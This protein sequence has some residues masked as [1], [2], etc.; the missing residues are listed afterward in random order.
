MS[1]VKTDEDIREDVLCQMAWDERLAGEQVGVQVAHG[2]VTLGGVVDDWIKFTAAAEAAHRV[3]DV[4]DVANEIQV[5]GAAVDTPSD[6]D[7]AISVRRALRWDA[8]LPEGDIR[9]TVTGGV[10]TLEGVVGSAA[11]RTEA[12]RAIRRL[13]GV[14]RI[15]NRLHVAERP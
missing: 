1:A 11:Q 8:R 6:T 5:R 13:H 10:V 2:V 12:S 14:R 7:L 3:P 4:T 15:D 9:T